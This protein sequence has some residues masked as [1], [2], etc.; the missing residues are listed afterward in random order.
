M[1]RDEERAQSV[2]DTRR[3]LNHVRKVETEGSAQRSEKE[4]RGVGGGAEESTERIRVQKNND[5]R[6]VTK[7]QSS[8][9]LGRGFREDMKH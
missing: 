8:A 7:T 3:A 6:R 9:K 5:T 2:P 4:H 1:G